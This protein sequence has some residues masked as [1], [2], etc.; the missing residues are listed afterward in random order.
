MNKMPPTITHWLEWV[1]F[2]CMVSG[3]TTP[4]SGTK[5]FV[6]KMLEAGIIGGI[7]LYGTV[8]VLGVKIEHHKEIQQEF[9]EEVKG[10]F[11]EVREEFKEQRVII[12]DL[13]VAVGKL[14]K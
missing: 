10:E 12:T 13:Q 8:E 7:I 4:P 1:P 5:Q 9:K 3:H 11:Q 6:T 14:E 2:A